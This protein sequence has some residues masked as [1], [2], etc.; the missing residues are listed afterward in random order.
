MLDGD[1]EAYYGTLGALNEVPMNDGWVVDIGG[2]SAEIS[3]VRD[4]RFYRGQAFT[5]GALALTERFVESDPVKASEFEALQEEIEGQLATAPW[6][7]KN[8]NGT[9]VGLGAPSAIWPRSRRSVRSIHST[10]CTASS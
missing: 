5:L 4:R 8:K 9:F 3:Q 6:L 1:R 2:G 10:P 7:A